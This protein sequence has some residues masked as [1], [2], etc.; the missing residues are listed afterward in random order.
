MLRA[1]HLCLIILA[2]WLTACA[3]SPPATRPAAGG[4][5][6]AAPPTARTPPPATVAPSATPQ[7]ATAPAATLAPPTPPPAATGTV[8]AP[9]PMDPPAAT[10][11]W[12]VGGA[13]H[14]ADNP[15]SGLGGLDAAGERVYVADRLGGVYIYDLDGAYQGVISAGEIG[16][17]TDVKVGP[18]G[19]VY[20]ADAALHQITLFNADLDLLGGF[21]SYGAGEGEFGSDSPAALA[22]SPDGELFVLD[23]NEDAGGAKVMRVLVFSATGEFLRSFPA[24][25]GMDAVG[26]DF[27]PDGTLFIVNR[28]GYVAEVE[29][30]AGRLIQRVGEAALAGAWPQMIAADEAGN[31]YVTTQIPTAVAV[32]SA[33]GHGLIE[34]IGGEGVRTDEG[35]P[36]GEFLSPFGVAVTGDG[37]RVFTG[38]TADPFSYVTAFGRR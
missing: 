23:P 38:D 28:Q 8:A 12:R 13:R 29:P 22:V 14:A 6:D 11:R 19:T 18:D 27:G 32:L 26:M 20:I 7:P 4:A 1:S 5:S 35:W 34:W 3:D 17:L 9:S 36:A 25:P 15:F 37:R 31:L 10:V 2:L 33:Q 24:E 30:E 21:G 16:Y